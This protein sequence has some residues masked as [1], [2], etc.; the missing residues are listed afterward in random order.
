M[1]RLFIPDKAYLVFHN[2]VAKGYTAGLPVKCHM[3]SWLMQLHAAVT[4]MHSVGVVYLDLHPNNTKFKLGADS[5]V[6]HVILIDF[7]SALPSSE[8]GEDRWLV[9]KDVVDHVHRGEWRKAYPDILEVGQPAPREADWFFIAAVLLGHLRGKA[10]GWVKGPGRA[11]ALDQV[12]TLLE[13]E[14]AGLLACIE[15]V[16]TG[17]ADGVAKMRQLKMVDEGASLELETSVT[18]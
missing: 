14:R 18:E 10:E 6:E 4:A 2:L 11:I 7:D 3:A 9:R 12:K 13:M 15:D 5:A 1:N 8:T 16:R 17:L